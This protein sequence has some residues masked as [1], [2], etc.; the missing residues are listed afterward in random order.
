[1]SSYEHHTPEMRD[2]QARGK[3]AYSRENENDSDEEMHRLRLGRG[4]VGPSYS[5]FSEG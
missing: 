5:P 1:M 3:D 2:R 4:H